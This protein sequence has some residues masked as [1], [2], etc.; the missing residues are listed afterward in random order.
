MRT[1]SDRIGIGDSIYFSDG[2]SYHMILGVIACYPISIDNAIPTD[3]TTCYG[4]STG[5][6]QVS[7]SGG[8]GAPWNYSIDDGD[9]YQE[10]LTLFPDL[11]AGEY[12]V[13]VY[14]SEGCTQTGPVL[15][16]NEPEEL[17]INVVSTA[18]VTPKT[19]GHIEVEASGGSFPYTYTL[20]PNGTLQGFGT[21]G[22]SDTG[23]YVVEVNDAKGC[24]PVSTDTI[25]ILD[26][27]LPISIEGVNTIGTCNGLSTGSIQISASGGLGEPWQY[28][29]DS[30]VTFQAESIF[31]DLPAGDYQIVVAD[32]ENCT[33]TGPDT[34]I[35][36]ADPLSIEIISTSD[37]T[38]DG[39]GQIV[40][41]ASGGTSPYTY[42]LT[43][44]SVEQI[45]DGIF[46]I[47]TS[48][49]YTVE[50]NDDWNCGPVTTGEILY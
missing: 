3:V 47:L 14:D 25:I 37:I 22:I 39:P 38:A 30:G 43:P 41:E 18:D 31:A 23:S 29:I 36:E 10:D 7:A 26:G 6:I 48:G 34:T 40:V 2:I 21:F 24:G 50:V 32:L 49:T 19:E 13:K 4:D 9:T 17:L 20:Q 15:T 46:D 11:P 42:T 16:I 1:N 5:S 8:F 33:A 45:D 27:C 35:L 28:S 12:Q 44:D